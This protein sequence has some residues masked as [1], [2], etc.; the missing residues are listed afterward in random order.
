[1]LRCIVLSLLFATLT[2][3]RG[4]DGGT[5]ATPAGGSVQEASAADQPIGSTLE[6]QVELHR[7]GFSCGSIDGVAGA[8]TSAALRAF[9]RAVG[10]ADTGILDSA[11]RENLRLTAPALGEYSF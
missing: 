8:Q 5:V 4:E 11:T 7:R 9:Q 3:V 2:P 6:L 10:I 1:M